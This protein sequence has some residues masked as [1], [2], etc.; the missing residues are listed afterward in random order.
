MI[1]V[2]ISMHLQAADFL[3][4]VLED[5]VIG[6]WA[7]R[8]AGLWRHALPRTFGIHGADR[9]LAGGAVSRNAKAAVEMMDERTRDLAK[10]KPRRF[11]IAGLPDG[12]WI[13]SNDGEVSATQFGDLASAVAFARMEAEEK[14]ADV[15]LWIDDLY[16]FIHQPEGWPNAICTPS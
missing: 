15:E 4:P 2:E 3:K 1:E 5:G 13:V 8:V 7:R 10:P 16:I 6:G 14:E 12:K 11:A 9:G